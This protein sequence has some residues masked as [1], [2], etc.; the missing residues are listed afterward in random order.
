MC[1]Q[2]RKKE[3]GHENCNRIERKITREYY[4]TEKVMRKQRA[5]QKK[6]RLSGKEKIMKKGQVKTMKMKRVKKESKNGGERE[7]GQGKGEN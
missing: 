1:K 3:K 2:E 6:N 7:K 5:R 4:R